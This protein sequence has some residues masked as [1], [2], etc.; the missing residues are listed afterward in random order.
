MEYS[1]KI[2]RTNFINDNDS[3]DNKNIF[4][5]VILCLQNICGQRR[6]TLRGEE[7]NQIA[8]ESHF[9]TSSSSQ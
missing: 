3:N 9:N 5:S 2:R 6:Y 1:Q 7:S 4:I 8:R